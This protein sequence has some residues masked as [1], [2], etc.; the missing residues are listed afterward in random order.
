MSLAGVVEVLGGEKV[1]QHDLTGNQR[2]KM[3]FLRTGRSLPARPY[4]H[5]EEGLGEGH[6]WQA[7]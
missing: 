5:A 3:G 6:I 2:K 1:L 7:Y 4:R